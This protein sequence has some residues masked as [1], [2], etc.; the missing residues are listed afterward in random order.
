MQYNETIGYRIRFL[1]PADHT[2]GWFGRPGSYGGECGVF[3][4]KHN[5]CCAVRANR[6]KEG[7]YEIWKVYIGNNPQEYFEPERVD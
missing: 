1:P 2:K 7:E 3:I 4:N 5:A 6:L